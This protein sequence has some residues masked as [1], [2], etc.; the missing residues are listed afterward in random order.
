MHYIYFILGRPCFHD[1]PG[2]PGG[3]Y[4]SLFR[5]YCLKGHAVERVGFLASTKQGPE[6]YTA[7]WGSISRAREIKISVFL[8]A[9]HGV[10]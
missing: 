4:L 5:I 7:F 9:I 2:V 10:F 1:R 6:K 3:Q 8:R